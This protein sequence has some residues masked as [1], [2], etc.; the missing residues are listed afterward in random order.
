MHLMT[1]LYRSLRLVSWLVLVL[2]LAA[3]A[4]SVATSIRYWSGIGV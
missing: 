3:L 2:M 1:G 4:W